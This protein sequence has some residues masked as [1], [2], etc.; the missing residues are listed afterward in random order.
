[1]KL[2]DATKNHRRSSGDIRRYRQDKSKKNQYQTLSKSEV[3]CFDGSQK[4][5]NDVSS[6]IKLESLSISKDFSSQR[7]FDKFRNKKNRVLSRY[8]QNRVKLQSPMA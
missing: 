6:T 3:N 4:E 8:Q 7:K 2:K 5:N 1:M